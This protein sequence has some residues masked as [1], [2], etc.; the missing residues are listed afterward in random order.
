MKAILREGCLVAVAGV[1]LAYA[2]NS[3]SPR[4]LKLTT[5]YFPSDRVPTNSTPA[6]TTN[7]PLRLAVTN[8]VEELKKEL[9]AKNMKL[10]ESN[11]VSHTPQRA[12][13]GIKS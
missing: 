5:D 1:V 4:G 2:A 7:L 9:L 3:V 8:G 10:A 11:E 13:S 12:V 6:S